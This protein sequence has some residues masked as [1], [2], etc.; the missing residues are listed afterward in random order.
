MQGIDTG[1]VNTKAHDVQ[2]PKLPPGDYTFIVSA[3]NNDGVW[4]THPASLHFIISPPLWATW[5]A[6]SCFILAVI[7]F[8]YWRIKAV[9]MREKRKSEITKQLTAAELR[10]LKAQFDPHFFFNNLNTLSHLIDISPVNAQEYVDELSQFYH[11]TL[12]NR[13]KEFTELG[14]EVE[15]AMRYYNLLKIR[16]GDQLKVEWNINPQYGKNFILTN[17]LQLLLEN[18]VKHNNI[19]SDKPLVVEITTS[20]KNT[21]F[22]KNRVQLKKKVLSTGVGLT[23]VNELYLLL[24]GKKININCTSEYFSVE[25]PLLIPKEYEDINYRR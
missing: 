10:E 3:R 16:F 14:N 24:S 2:Y 20:E 5:W 4:S 1:W 7:G 6:R 22:V 17:S 11:Y 23:S 8:V 9:E 18:V 13:K 21:I 19:T 12:N 25:L 15:Q